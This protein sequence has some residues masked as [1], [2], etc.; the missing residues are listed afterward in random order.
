MPRRSPQQ[1]Q[2]PDPALSREIREACT[3]LSIAYARA[4]DFRDYESFVELFTEDGELDTGRPLVG[5]TAIREAM[6]HRPDELKSRHVLS[7]IFID[8]IDA[9]T[10]RGI[11]YLTLYRHVG[12]ESL[13][14]QPIEFSGPAAVGH[15]EDQFVRAG[16]GFLFSRRKLH[17]T[18]R[19]ADKF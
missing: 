12:P 14:G 8:V 13:R 17:L 6:R 3:A 18:F 7:N 2:R 15:Y 1:A 9:D 16:D 19:R 5:R 10:A 4:V 11:S